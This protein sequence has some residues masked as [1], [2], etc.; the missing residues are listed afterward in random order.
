MEKKLI[1]GF[2]FLIFLFNFYFPITDAASAE[3]ELVYKS[4]KSGE[5][6]ISVR[7]E[8]NLEWTDYKINVDFDKSENSIIGV[9]DG[10]PN[11]PVTY[12][13][14]NIGNGCRYSYYLGYESPNGVYDLIDE[15]YISNTMV[16]CPN[17][18]IDPNP[19]DGD[20]E[21]K[22]SSYCIPGKG[23]CVDDSTLKRCS[24]D[25]SFIE[26]INCGYKCTDDQCLSLGYDL[27]V[28]TNKASYFYGDN[29]IVTGEFKRVE[30]D[31][32]V[33]GANILAQVMKSGAVIDEKTGWTDGQG[34]V[35]FNFEDVELVG[36]VTI[37]LSTR[38][39]DKDYNKARIVNFVGEPIKEEVTAG[40]EGYTQ[41]NNNP[42]TFRVKLEDMNGN[43]ISP[44]RLNNIEAVTSLSNGEILSNE[45][46]FRGEGVYI[47]SSEVIGTGNFVG[48]L[49]FEYQKTMQNTNIVKIEVKQPQIVISN[50]IGSSSM[51]ND[52]NT[53]TL[54]ISD[55][56]G[57]KINPD[58]IW[59][60]VTYPDGITKDIIDMED[61]N[62]I[63]NSTFKF[64]YTFSQVEKYSFDIFATKSGYVKGHYLATVSI[65]GESE[66][67]A[68]PSWLRY[69]AQISI[70]FII[71]FFISA[72]LLYWFKIRKK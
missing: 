51:L 28:S 18:V 17:S 41:Y 72:F 31:Y 71:L 36:E 45:V 14:N 20:E 25:G 57:E 69:T 64:N 15:G 56:R 52:T 66:F 43:P 34:M 21:W 35:D 22:C 13:Y 59:I 10:T 7:N 27:L 24:L 49:R 11:L 30:T 6:K 40:R 5:C 1:V 38:Y 68:G 62:R 54:S 50:D 61:M 3:E 70:V 12:D 16:S 63:D 2:L 46:D 53:Y 65:T 67:L 60:E 29:L 19:Y 48:K 44:D 39:R 8:D 55:V 58:N 47:I 37:K 33:E 32:P 42:I 23:V 9:Y 26:E 4:Y